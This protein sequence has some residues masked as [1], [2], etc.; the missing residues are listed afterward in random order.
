MEDTRLPD[1]FVVC[2]HGSIK[3]H[4]KCEE[5]AIAHFTHFTQVVSLEGGFYYSHVCNQN[6]RMFKMPQF[7]PQPIDPVLSNGNINFGNY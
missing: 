1:H 3:I 5:K 7:Q 4:T 6:N 2:K